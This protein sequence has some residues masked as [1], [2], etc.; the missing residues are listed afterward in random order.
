M[1]RTVR[2]RRALVSSV[3]RLGTGPRNAPS[4]PVTVSREVEPLQ[5]EVE[6]IDE[7]LPELAEPGALGPSDARN[8]INIVSMIG[9]FR[10]MDLLR[11]ES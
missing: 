9:S 4:V 1:T 8:L 6:Q 11:E 7:A 5:E 3:N 10:M 2:I